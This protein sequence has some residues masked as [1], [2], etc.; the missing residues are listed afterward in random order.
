MADLEGAV[1]RSVQRRNL[2]GPAAVPSWGWRPPKRRAQ[3]DDTSQYPPTLQSLCAQIIGSRIRS[4]KSR[5]TSFSLLPFP[6][7]ESIMAAAAAT[8]KLTDDILPLFRDPDLRT[9][10]LCAASVTLEGL[11]FM[12]PNGR[13]LLSHEEDD[14]GTAVDPHV[15][16]TQ[17]SVVGD[18]EDLL[19]DSTTPVSSGCPELHTL[20]ISFCRRL[21][22]IRTASLI[23]RTVPT[24]SFLDI[25]GCFDYLEGPS[26][27]TILAKNLINLRTLKVGYMPWLT[28]FMVLGIP[29]ESCLRLLEVLSAAD[30]PLLDSDALRREMKTL[31]GSVLVLC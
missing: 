23:S 18:W 1:L 7:K 4:Y 5:H 20:D 10:T 13:E 21:P 14:M 29:W 31:R 25:S 19:D 12:L 17:K 16:N 27:L 26:A 30:C 8:S 11:A 15:G 22:G 3:T 28:D 6:Q 9:C 2:A 24:L